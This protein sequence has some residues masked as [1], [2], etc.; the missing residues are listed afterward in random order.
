MKKVL[1]FIAILGLTGCSTILN[2]TNQEIKVT[3]SNLGNGSI[4]VA[5]SGTQYVETLP[6]LLQTHPSDKKTPI[7]I[8]TVGSCI[9]PNKIILR[10]QLS[11]YYWLNVLNG[12]GFF[13]DYATGSM[14]QYPETAKIEVRRK[15]YCQESPS[16]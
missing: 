9:H 15:D 2:G 4:E 5:S 10:T 14:W 1:T 11:N 8:S 7:T 3:A 6:V 16:T 13:I 12:F